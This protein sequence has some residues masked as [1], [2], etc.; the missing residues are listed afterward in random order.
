MAHAFGYIPAF[1][2]SG[3][4]LRAAQRLSIDKDA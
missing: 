3:E 1:N 2:Q 4:L